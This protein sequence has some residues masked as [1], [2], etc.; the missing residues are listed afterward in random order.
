MQNGIFK[1]EFIV[2]S[3]FS[4]F[5]GIDFH[6]LFVS[7]LYRNNKVGTL[8]IPS[9]HGTNNAFLKVLSFL[10]EEMG[11]IFLPLGLLYSIFVVVNSASCFLSVY[12]QNSNTPEEID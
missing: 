8:H 9:V 6:I 2:I 10:K 1:T 5:P 11:N 4:P 12:I 3:Y 7:P